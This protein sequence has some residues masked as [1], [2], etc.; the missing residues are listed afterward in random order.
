MTRILVGLALCIVAAAGPVRGDSAGVLTGRIITDSGPPPR[1]WY[2][3]VFPVDRALWVSQSPRIAAA[4]SDAEGRWIV[5]SLPAGDY[6][7]AV[8][9]ALVPGEL[10]DPSFLRR[11]TPA[12][13][14]VTLAEGEQ[15]TQDLR[16]G[17]RF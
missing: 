3:V 7:L 11:V 10:S 4:L 12:A 8:V 17:S 15:K 16:L 1:P 14:K 9:T 6:F 5:R 2:V 13:F